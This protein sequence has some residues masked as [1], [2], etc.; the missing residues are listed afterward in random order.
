MAAGVSPDG[1]VT[2]G[3]GVGGAVIRQASEA[4]K[5]SAS[6]NEG[7]FRWEFLEVNIENSPFL[8]KEI[9]RCANRTDSAFWL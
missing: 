6:I 2:T 5:S 4:N 1:T 9:T 8:I 7:A 3:V